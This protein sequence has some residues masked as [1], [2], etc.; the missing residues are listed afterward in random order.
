MEL[1]I[2]REYEFTPEWHG[3][4]KDA[5]PIVFQMR[6]LTTGERD[7]F[8]GYNFSTDGQLQIT[9]DRQGMFRA[10]VTGIKNLKVNGESLTKAAE[11]LARPGLDGLYAEAVT[12]IISQNGREDL[13]N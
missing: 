7:R 1:T 4:K 11:V 13:K 12:E 8:M 6:M 5:A 3:N 10:A 2:D 9:P